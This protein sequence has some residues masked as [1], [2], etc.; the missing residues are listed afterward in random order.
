LEPQNVNAAAEFLKVAVGCNQDSLAGL[1]Q[2]GRKAIHIR[3]FVD[4]FDF[5]RFQ[6]LRNIHGNKIK[7][8]TRQT[9]DRTP[10]LFLAMPLPQV[11]ED[12]SP[13]HHGD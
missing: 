6:N 9:P 2:R 8:E 4:C 1:R 7:R 5:T 10:G 12:F 11:V 13:I 3:Y